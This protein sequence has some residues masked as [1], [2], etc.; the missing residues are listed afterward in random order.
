MGRKLVSKK[1]KK[2]YEA[3]FASLSQQGSLAFINGD[4]TNAIKLYTTALTVRQDPD[5]LSNR[6]LAYTRV[7]S[8]HSAKRDFEGILKKI[9][10]SLEMFF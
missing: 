7:R 9:R 1:K 5:T 10:V 2:G 4:M 3:S 6:G 8:F